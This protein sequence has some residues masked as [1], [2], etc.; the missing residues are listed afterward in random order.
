MSRQLDQQVL[1]TDSTSTQTLFIVYVDDQGPRVL[2]EPI[3]KVVFL[4][5]LNYSLLNSS[6]GLIPDS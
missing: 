5:N 2:R 4:P 3:S 6:S 1:T